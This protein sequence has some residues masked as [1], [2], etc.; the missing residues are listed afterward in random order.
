MNHGLIPYIGG[1][2]RLAKRLVE[3]CIAGEADTFV[4]VFG[5]S[6]AVTLAAAEKY[7]KLIYNDVDG[8]L[9]NLFRVVA[10]PQARVALFRLLRWLPPSRQIYEEDYQRYRA[11]GFSFCREPDP[12]RRARM[13]FYRHA[14]V[15][16]GKVRCG[17]FAV[18]T[19]DKERIKEV[20]RYRNML[21]KLA[22]V[23]NLFRM[24]LIENQHYSEII[25]Q[26]ARPSAVLFIDPPYHGSENYYSRTFGDGDHVFL[27]QQLAGVPSRV[28]CTYYDT[29][30]IRQLYPAP[31]WRWENVAA[32]KNSCL[33]R[34]NKAIAN[35][36]CIVKAAA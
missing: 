7:A 4:D 15:F 29:P 5:G 24:V 16:G 9:V 11:G 14:F 23:G 27:A 3:F 33:T 31:L 13:T 10:D 20:Y 18:S 34:G 1:K 26:Y 21:Q 12:I 2:H 8:D 17:G 19:G 6:A 30:L 36:W 28:V 25:R 32:T 35:E 22:R